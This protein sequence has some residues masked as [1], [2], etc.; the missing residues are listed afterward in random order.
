MKLN[1]NICSCIK[2]ENQKIIMSV[3]YKKM[4]F[5]NIQESFN[6]PNKFEIFFKIFKNNYI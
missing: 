5:Q 6:T 3:I 4:Y 1:K 2:T